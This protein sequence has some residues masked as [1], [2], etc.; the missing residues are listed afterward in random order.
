MDYHRP[1]EYW[2]CVKNSIPLS[3]DNHTP[4]IPIGQTTFNIFKHGV[5]EELELLEHA[6]IG[7]VRSYIQSIQSIY[8]YIEKILKAKQQIHKTNKNRKCVFLY[9]SAIISCVRI[10]TDL[11]QRLTKASD[12]FSPPPY[13]AQ[14][15]PDDQSPLPPYIFRND[16]DA[17]PYDPDA[18]PYEQIGR[19]MM[20]M[21]LHNKMSYLTLTQ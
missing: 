2:I 1:V 10:K 9:G 17:R 13:I 12:H 15:D 3:N 16:P 11:E 5:D 18:P 6:S 7:H 4:T 14:N 8:T 21:Y 19:G 20:G